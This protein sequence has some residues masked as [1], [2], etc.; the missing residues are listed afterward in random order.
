[1][2]ASA[3]RASVM[4]VLISKSS[5]SQVYESQRLTEGL[6]SC[7]LSEGQRVWPGGWYGL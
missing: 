6:K 2:A 4:D 3:L 1:M 5:G 7:A